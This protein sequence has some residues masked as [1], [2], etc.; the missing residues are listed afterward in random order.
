[1]MRKLLLAATAILA[2]TGAA[3]GDEFKEY[4][5][6]GAWSVEAGEGFCMA[7][8]H[9]DH[10]DNF[11]TFAIAGNG[12]ASITITNPKWHIPEGEY[13]IRA[14]VDDKIPANFTA[15]AEK[16]IV[17]WGIALGENNIDILSK[18]SLLH[19]YIGDKEHTYGLNGS[20]AMLGSLIRCVDEIVFGSNPFSDPPKTAPVSTPSNPFK[21]T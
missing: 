5:K 20:A 4:A 1:M 19:V 17:S 7:S 10:N 15:N 13:E 12:K 21:R 3:H 11:L 14:A 9:Y 6:V 2:L 8:A 18:G 16:T